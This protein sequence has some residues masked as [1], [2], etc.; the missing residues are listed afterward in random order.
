MQHTLTA[1]GAHTKG[2]GSQH[3]EGNEPTLT[4]QKAHTKG[5]ESPHHQHMEPT[6]RGQVI[7][8]AC[9]LRVL[10]C[11]GSPGRP[12]PLRLP[13]C[14]YCVA[15]LSSYPA[16]R[17]HVAGSSLYPAC[18]Y[19]V[20]GSSSYPAARPLR[21]STG[22]AGRSTSAPVSGVSRPLYDRLSAKYSAASLAM[23]TRPPPP[24][25][26]ATDSPPNATSCRL[27][28]LSSPSPE[29][30]PPLPPSAASRSLCDTMAS[31]KSSG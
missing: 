23:A 3:H 18:R 20:A 24:A 27:V 5:T 28:R 14:R 7:P 22:A 12:S 30:S 11:R 2:T 15:G 10:R 4:A 6:L 26:P 8:S 19:R 13:T 16:C 1:Q 21:P 9:F 17:Y 25:G 29:R 31:W